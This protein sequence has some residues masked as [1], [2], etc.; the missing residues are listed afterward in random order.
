[1]DNTH[2]D[3]RFVTRIAVARRRG[4]AFP[5]HRAPLGRRSAHGETRL[6]RQSGEV[7]DPVWS[8]ALET[9]GAGA[10]AAGATCSTPG[11]AGTTVDDRAVRTSVPR[12][13]VPSSFDA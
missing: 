10:G 7:S 12:G 2:H 8:D 3:R 6:P 5:Q 9:A 13:P 4:A 1:M 11:G